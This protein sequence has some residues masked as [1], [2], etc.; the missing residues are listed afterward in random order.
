[1]N[2]AFCPARMVTGSPNP[3]IAKRELLDVAAVTVTFDP[4]AVRL[5]DAVPLR[6]AKT[7][8][9]AIGAG[10]AVSCPAVVEL[11]PETAMVRVG[12]EPFDVTVTLPL[13]FPADS[14]ANFT[15]N[16]ALCPAVSVAGVE[17]PLKVNPVPLMP[18]LEIV[19]LEPPVLV[20]VS[21]CT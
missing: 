3:L 12:L 7:V 6:P 15:L 19:T 14:G 9:S 13:A 8:P 21:D 5:P 11:A 16:V 1:M 2:G 4:V 18:T 10:L 17:I 20:T